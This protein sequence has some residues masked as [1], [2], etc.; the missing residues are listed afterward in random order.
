MLTKFRHVLPD[1]F[2]D[3]SDP[4]L[5]RRNL[6]KVTLFYEEFNL[7]VVKET[8]AFTLGGYL[9]DLGGLFGLCLGGSLLTVA[10]ILELLLDF[11]TVAHKKK[12]YKKPNG[13][14]PVR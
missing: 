1:L 4:N 14:S 8:P 2:L 7:R 6:M 3:P 5:F 9:S 12:A 11:V 10:E 13:V